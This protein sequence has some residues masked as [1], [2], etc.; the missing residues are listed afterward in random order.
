VILES[1]EHIGLSIK[2]V[3][4]Q[5][6]IHDLSHFVANSR[7]GYGFTRAIPQRGVRRVSYLTFRQ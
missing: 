6:G 2:E 3:A 7:V 5:V 1:E 4:A